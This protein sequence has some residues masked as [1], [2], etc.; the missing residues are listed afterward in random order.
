MS[1]PPKVGDYSKEFIQLFL[2]LL[3]ALA[4]SEYLSRRLISTHETLQKVSRDLPTKV[5]TSLMIDWPKSG[6]MEINNLVSNFMETTDSL[7][8]MFYEIQQIN[9]S[10]EQQ[11]DERTNELSNLMHEVNIILENAPIGIA[12]VVDRKIVWTNYKMGEIFN[13]SKNELE[14]QLT[15]KLYPSEEAFEK[16]AMEAYPLLLQGL[17]FDVERELVSKDGVQIQ[18]RFIGKAL[19]PTD[20]RKGTIWLLEDITIRKQEEAEKRAFEHQ[21]QETQRLESLGVLAGGIAHDFNNL[22]AIIIGHCSL[23]VM[24]PEKFE[25]NIAAITTVR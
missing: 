6:I 3:V 12:K 10:L 16:L 15:R 14:G 7:A 22:L 25:T 20:M 17:V 21:F 23:A 2:T 8:A 18:I 9:L 13:Y 19:D 24:N 5:A 11:I 1:P 4:I